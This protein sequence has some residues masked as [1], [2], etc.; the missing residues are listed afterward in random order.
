MVRTAVRCPGAYCY[1]VGCAPP[2]VARPIAMQTCLCTC[3]EHDPSASHVARA[4]VVQTRKRGG[5]LTRNGLIKPDQ[6]LKSH[7]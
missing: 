3:H 6:N 4:H 7:H 1:W 5:K 2:P